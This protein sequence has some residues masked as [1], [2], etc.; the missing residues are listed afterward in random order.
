[1]LKFGGMSTF[2]RLQQSHFAKIR[3]ENGCDSGKNPT[4]LIGKGPGL[5]PAAATPL[6]TQPLGVTPYCR[7][8]YSHPSNSTDHLPSTSGYGDTQLFA[9]ET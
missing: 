9:L 8:E 2:R 6:L 1:M 5:S 3:G 7:P 4:A